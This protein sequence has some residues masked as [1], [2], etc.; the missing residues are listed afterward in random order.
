MV[1]AAS[2]Q[3]SA[4]PLSEEDRILLLKLARQAI[5]TGVQ[6]ERLARLD[7]KK[8][9]S[10]L[11]APGASFV[12][13]T[14]S[15]RLRGCIGTLE[16]YQALAEDVREHAQAA[17]FLDSRFPPVTANELASLRIEI[18]RLTPP[19]ELAYDWPDELPA[20]IRPH[21]DGVTLMDGLRRATFLPQVWEKID[22]PDEF[23]D[24]LCAKMGASPDTWKRR[25]LR[26]QTYQVEEFHD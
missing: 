5:E 12:T 8:L 15:G 25:V 9:P 20:K 3:K 24:H 4:L 14:R 19:E 13:L 18:S 16:A 6:G 17:A 11:Q 26:V 2:P 7:L 22:S 1:N 10:A 21:M 23:L